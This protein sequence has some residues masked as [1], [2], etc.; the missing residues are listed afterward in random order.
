MGN[1]RYKKR[2]PNRHAKQRRRRVNHHNLA[3]SR[4]G[5]DVPHN[6]VRLWKDGTLEHEDAFHVLFGNRTLTE[7][8][9]VLLR[10]DRAIKKKGR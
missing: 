7:A 5:P 6:F 10:L 8:A 1:R 9:E 2:H 3:R 4:G